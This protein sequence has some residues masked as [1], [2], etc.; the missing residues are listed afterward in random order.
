MSEEE[1]DD[2]FQKSRYISTAAEIRQYADLETLNAKRE[3]LFNFWSERERTQQ[4]DKAKLRRDYMKR[5]ELS[6]ERFG[7]IQRAGW[8]T[9]RGRVFITYGEPSEIERFP[10]QLDAK[11]YEI[12]HYN[13]L[14]GGVIFVFADLTG[15]SDFIL[16]H[17]T[18]RGELRDENWHRKVSSF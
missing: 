17:S 12:W 7:N 1:C 13:H 18:L 15:F 14:D 9:D 5:I 6:N 3:F 16:L 11:P 8:K 10:S 2:L 4:I